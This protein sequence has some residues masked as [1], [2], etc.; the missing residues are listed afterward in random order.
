M[1]IGDS[2]ASFVIFYYLIVLMVSIM[3]FGI[4]VFKTLTRYC[5]FGRLPSAAYGKYWEIQGHSLRF[6][7][8]CHILFVE[9]SYQL[10]RCSTHLTS[11]FLRSFFFPLRMFFPKVEVMYLAGGVYFCIWLLNKSS[12]VTLLGHFSANLLGAILNCLFL[13]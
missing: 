5:L 1:I 12:M 2:S 8:L 10:G 6:L 11:D 7:Q 4:T 13:F 9:N 3:Q